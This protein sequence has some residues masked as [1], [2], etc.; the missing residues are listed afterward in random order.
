MSDAELPLGRETGYPEQYA[1][2]L[3]YPIARSDSRESLGKDDLPFHGTDIW[4]AW[5]LTW[6][7]PGGVP[8][9]ATAEIRIPAST[10]NLVESKSLKLYLNSFAMTVCENDAEVSEKIASDLGHC[11]GGPVSVTLMNAHHPTANAIAALPGTCIDTLTASATQ[12]VVDA[13]LLRADSNTV[14]D[15]TLHTHLLRSLCPVTSQP[16]IGSLMLRYSGPRIDP[17]SLLQ[18]VVSFRSHN[19]FHE[20]CVERMFI[21]IQQHCGA[22]QLSLYARYQRR[23]GLDINPFRSNFEFDPQNLR[24]WRQ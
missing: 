5:E 12:Y 22:E 16:D 4:N 2:D 24:L 11:A 1:P 13:S 7:S 21:D 9:V 19:D 23:G 18:Y 10:P 17:A 3:L 6:L 14:V 15:E 8:A 20:A